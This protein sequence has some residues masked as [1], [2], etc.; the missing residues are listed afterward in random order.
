M[1]CFPL[2]FTTDGLIASAFL[3][4]NGQYAKREE[5]LVTVRLFY[6]GGADSPGSTKDLTPEQ[7]GA[8]SEEDQQRIRDAGTS[9]KVNL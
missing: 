8:L 6:T 4:R 1:N 5:D 3:D 7:F 2:F 9:V